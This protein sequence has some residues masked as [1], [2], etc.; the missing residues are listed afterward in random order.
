MATLST[1]DFVGL[2]TFCGATIIAIFNKGMTDGARIGAARLAWLLAGTAVGIYVY[3]A[4]GGMFYALHAEEVA[5]R[6]SRGASFFFTVASIRCSSGSRFLR[7][8][9]P[10]D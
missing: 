6:S 2:G 9:W 5:A 1:M 10:R 8:A 7:L 4:F 3:G